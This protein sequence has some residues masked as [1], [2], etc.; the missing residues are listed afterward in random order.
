MKTFKKLALVTAIAAAPFAAQAMEALDDSVLGNTTGQAGVTIDMSIGDAGITIGSVTYTDTKGAAD[1]D[2][3]SVVLENISIKNITNLSQTI[4]VAG[5]GHLVMGMS[6][7]TALVKKTLNADGTLSNSVLTTAQTAVVGDIVDGVTLDA[8]GVITE[9]TKRLSAGNGVA[10]IQIALGGTPGTSA[11]MLQGT[12]AANQA[13]LVNNLSLN[14][15]LGDSTTTIYNMSG[16]ANTADYVAKGTAVTAAALA[17]GD[18]LVVDGA[19]TRA[20]TQ[21]DV[22]NN[23]LMANQLGYNGN[24]LGS[25]GVIGDNAAKTG[26]MAIKMNASFRL[27]DLDV[28]VFGYTQAQA[29]VKMGEVNAGIQTAA[30][31]ATAIGAAAVANEAI[32]AYNAA[33]GQTAVAPAVAGS[34]LTL[35]QQ[36]AVAAATASGSAIQI[37]NMSFMGS[38]GGM[39]TVDQT[40]WAQGGSSALGGG[41]YIQLGQ[42]AG[43]MNIGSISIGGSSIGSVSVADINLAGMTQ[44]IYGH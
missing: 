3:G 6:G 35:A 15:D 27:N 5:A 13:E 10:N 14:V 28:G 25:V 18:A 9:N 38:D 11:V 24:Q 20:A 16:N 37:E 8:A 31:G 44:R 1:S 40:I 17:T 21:T 23:V 43:T 2:G 22:D 7:D 29:T 30:A 39:V 42:I 12:T 41:V 33:S 34:E 32:T 26:A 19:G 36:T 4:D